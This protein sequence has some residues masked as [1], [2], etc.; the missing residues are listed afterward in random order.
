M[1]NYV[2]VLLHEH[3][4]MFSCCAS[5]RLQPNRMAKIVPK[6]NVLPESGIMEQGH[7]RNVHR[8]PPF[9]SH[10]T[11]PVCATLRPYLQ[12]NLNIFIELY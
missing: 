8:F 3:F 2:Y 5:L 1:N 12:T 10:Q 9:L 6:I 4:N 7:Q 11:L